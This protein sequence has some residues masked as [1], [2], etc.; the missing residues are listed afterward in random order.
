MT[1]N[2]ALK[3]AL[4]FVAS[5]SPAFICEATHHKKNEWHTDN[6]PCPHVVK[7]KATYEAIKETLAQPDPLP[8]INKMSI[9]V[10]NQPLYTAPQRKPLTDEEVNK[11]V[12]DEDWYNDQHGFVRAIEAKLRSKNENR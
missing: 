5:I 1:K 9:D 6:E 8:W 4:D 10:P 12:D 11:L 7:Q 2:E 3:L